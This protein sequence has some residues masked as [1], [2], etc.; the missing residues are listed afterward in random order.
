MHCGPLWSTRWFFGIVNSTISYEDD[1]TRIVPGT[2]PLLVQISIVEID[3]PR[4]SNWAIGVNNNINNFDQSLGIEIL[5]QVQVRGS[6]MYYM[7]IH[8]QRRREPS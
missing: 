5:L 3:H 8:S 4:L 7:E 1:D 2:A 6:C